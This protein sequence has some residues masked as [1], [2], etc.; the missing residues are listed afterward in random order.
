MLGLVGADGDVCRSVRLSVGIGGSGGG[1][2]GE[3]SREG[4][5]KGEG[6]RGGASKGEGVPMNEYVG[7]LQ[8]RVR[9][10]PEPQSRGRS[11]GTLVGVIGKREFGLIDIYPLVSRL[12][13]RS[14][15]RQP[16]NASCDS[17]SPCSPCS[18]ESTSAPCV[19]APGHHLSKPMRG[20]C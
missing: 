14:G 13:G 9:E 19:A 16:S 20:P 3:G 4:S 18:S 5:F 11:K 1:F 2:T 15:V 6:S 8:N 12:G 17:D 7:G 10:Q